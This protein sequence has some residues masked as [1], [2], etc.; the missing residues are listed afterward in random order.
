MKYIFTI[1]IAVLSYY[2]AISQIQTVCATDTIVLEIENYDVGIIE[3]E[4]SIDGQVWTTIPNATGLTYKFHPVEEKYYRSAIKTSD[5]EPLYSEVSFVQFPPVANAGSDRKIGDTTMILLGNYINEGTGEWTLLSGTGYF[6]D[7]TKNNSRFY[8]HYGES[9]QLKWTITTDCGESSDT[10]SVNFKEVK[11]N[12]N[13]I[14]VDMTDE[15][16]SDSIDFANGIYK[17]AFSDSTIVPRD[18]TILIGMRE[19]ISFLRKISSFSKQDSIYT[20]YTTNGTLED[21]ILQGPI[22]IGDVI[23]NTITEDEQFL[24]SSNLSVFPT[25]ES[26]KKYEGVKGMKPIYFTSKNVR[27]RVGSREDDG[28][29]IDIDFS[30]KKIVSGD[31][32][33]ISFTDG[34]NFSITPNFVC[35]VDY[36]FPA[37]FKNIKFGIDNGN[38]SINTNIKFDVSTDFQGATSLKDEISLL[39]HPPVYYHWVVVAGAPILIVVEANIKMKYETKLGYG[40]IA[41]TRNNI[42]NNFSY[43]IEGDDLDDL[44]LTRNS[45]LSTH[46]SGDLDAKGEFSVEAK[47]GPEISFKI[48][49]VIGPYANLFLKGK[50]DLCVNTSG[51]WDAGLKAGFEANIGIEGEKW[52]VTFLDLEYNLLEKTSAQDKEKLPYELELL[53]GYCQIGSPDEKLPYPTSLKVKSKKGVGVPFV[54]VSISMEDGNGSVDENTLYTDNSGEVS[55]DWTLGEN[56]INELEVTV[57]DCDNEHIKKSPLKVQAS[58]GLDG[59]Y[60][61][62]NTDLEISFIANNGTTIPSGYG[63]TPPYTYST[64]GENYSSTVPQFNEANPGTFIV[65][66]KDA[67]G[68]YISRSVK[69]EQEDECEYTDLTLFANTEANTIN[70]SG[71]GGSP[72]YKFS[73]DNLN[74]FSSNR[75]FNNVVPGE[76][77]FYVKDAIGCINSITIDVEESSPALLAVYPLDGAHFVRTTDVI[78][79]WIAGNYSTYQAYDLYLK[80]EGQ[81]YTLLEEGLETNTYS[82]NEN[83][84]NGSTYYWK[85]AVKDDYNTVLDEREFTFSTEGNTTTPQK[86][87]LLYP[88]NY[89]TVANVPLTLNWEN[90]NGNFVYDLYFDDVD[91][92]TLTA[93][94]LSS[95]GYTLNNLQSGKIYYWKV[96]AKSLETGE[97]ATSD[98]F[99]FTFNDLIP[100]LTTSVISDIDQTTATCGGH[101]SSA[102]ATNVTKR[103]ICWSTSPY[104]TIQDEK[105][106]NG[107]GTGAFTSYLDYLEPSTTYYVRA[108]ATNSEGTAYGNQNEFTTLQ[109][110]SLAEV[111]TYDVE[112]IT[113]NSATFFGEVIDD[114][115]SYVTENGFCW[116]EYSNPT[117]DWD[118]FIFIGEGEV[119]LSTNVSDLDE[120]TTYYVRAYAINEIGIA[121]GEVEEFITL[122]LPQLTTTEPSNI[123]ESTATSGGNI[124][125]DGS[126]NIFN[127]GV[128]WSTSSNPTIADNTTSDGSGTGS[129]TSN[130]SGLD[131][132]TTYYVRAYA[133][134]NEGTAYGN[135]FDFTTENALCES[136][137]TFIYNGSSVTYGIVE[138]ANNRCWLDRNLGALQVATSST[139]E[140]AYGDLFQWGRLDDGHQER[141]SSTTS[142]Q[143]NSDVPGHDMFIYYNF[144]WRNPNNDDLWQGVYGINNPCPDGYRVPTQA[145]WETERQS[146]SYNNASGAFESPLKLPLSGSRDYWYGFIYDNGTVGSYWSTTV[147][148]SID[149]I[150]LKFYSGN[151]VTDQYLKG[152]GHC[153]RCIKD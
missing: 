84:E 20:F 56:P 79:E 95:F 136:S 143:S 53:N 11:V 123:T 34:S 43:L 47:I 89:A 27:N 74:S 65:Y 152:N 16:F 9:C 130:I 110:T 41:I 70:L 96:V 140:D 31:G 39:T 137:V 25:R 45:S 29:L 7:K 117:I 82:Y 30:G 112:D 142:T 44:H 106:S 3:W 38:I 118:D 141:S 42:T 129:F 18:S 64:D 145:E 5:C 139:D 46:S 153:V 144:D 113:S 132:S 76:H 61:C 97:T 63:G 94:N 111:E 6:E 52:G 54:K 66:I 12:Y 149:A 13:F 14:V 108:Y 107:S 2:N 88:E 104:P 15:I 148:S 121:Y 151:A 75:Y 1:I 22:G 77:T 114:G 125:A 60:T 103:G 55:F 90:Q 100:V 85:I 49:D 86:P 71:G 122:S 19:D 80:K 98:I 57:L 59:D 126:S 91:A 92:T 26:L 146:W 93:L 28:K 69:I 62:F 102:G 81:G 133:T 17:I 36:D 138:S 101:I 78:F 128:C 8:S 58:N 4:E 87:I 73:I 105:T 99:R 40:F 120:N 116:S 115:G 124:I 109:A 35:D 21:I 24:R 51:N 135:Q 127:R 50:A 119:Y 83:L 68:C 32:L 150:R 72:P 67:D 10:M 131:P 33:D 48:Y 23:N 147:T 37:K 134:N